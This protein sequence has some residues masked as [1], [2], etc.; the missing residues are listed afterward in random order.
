M[1]SLFEKF[2]NLKTW[3]QK[4]GS[5]INDKLDISGT[6]D[7]KYLVTKT[8]V[9]PDEKM[10][11]INLNICLTDKL[12]DSFDWY[13][14]SPNS[15]INLFSSHEKI[16]L[17]LIH[18]K[19]LGSESFYYPYIDFLPSLEDLS[20]HPVIS[21]FN[22]SLETLDELT[23]KIVNLI[24]PYAISFDNYN[25][26]LLQ[27][28]NLFPDFKKN[29]SIDLIKWSHLIVRTRAWISGGF[30]L[31][32]IMDLFQHETTSQMINKIENGKCIMSSYRDYKSG[33]IIYDT[34]G[35]KD[36]FEL[37]ATYGFV[38]FSDNIF[39]LNPNIPIKLKANNL[40]NDFIDKTGDFYLLSSGIQQNYFTLARLSNLSLNEL[41]GL[42]EDKLNNIKNFHSV[43]NELKACQNILSI[44]KHILENNKDIMDTALI[45][46]S[47]SNIL[48]Q[49]LSHIL[50]NYKYTIKQTINNAINH[51]NQLLNCPFTFT[52]DFNL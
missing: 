48:I 16:I 12:I 18:H 11:E 37:Y 50:L 8:F 25:N 23:I 17:I 20:Y 27:K 36:D 38:N 21:Y 41:E 47:N 10:L 49:S 32:P 51:W 3:C 22:L 46:K 24:K 2:S 19:I 40:T 14:N 15:K 5:F 1:N 9:E 29:I 26:I 42:T 52:I 45:L 28:I 30:I 7:N 33:E 39:K 43:D 34:Y 31:V 4:N 35:I 6:N 13:S 44:C